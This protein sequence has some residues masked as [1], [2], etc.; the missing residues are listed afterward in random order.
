MKDSMKDIIVIDKSSLTQGYKQGKNS[1]R[2]WFVEVIFVE[3]ESIGKD[4]SQK[5]TDCSLP[6]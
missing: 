2:L 4:I 6:T 1:L 5:A 3:D